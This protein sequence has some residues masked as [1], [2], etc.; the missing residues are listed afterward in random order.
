MKQEW[1]CE[2]CKTSGTVTIDSDAGVYEVILLLQDS[3]KDKSP[4]CVNPLSG[5][6]VV[7]RSVGEE[8]AVEHFA[9]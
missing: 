3:H 5:L 6:R 9:D 8:S 2:V 4:D 1:F 7:N